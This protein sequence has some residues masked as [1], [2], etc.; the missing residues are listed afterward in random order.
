MRRL[1][2]PG[3]LEP[4]SE[5]RLPLPREQTPDDPAQTSRDALITPTYDY[6]VLT[7]AITRPDLHTHIFPG[8]LRLVGSA[9]V[10]WLINVDAVRTGHSVEA[11]IAN[12]ARLITAPNI[13]LEFLP[14]DGPGCFFQAA[15]RLAMRAGELLAQCRTGVVWLEDDWRLATRNHGQQAMSW[16]RY[17]V[18][19]NPDGAPLRRCL[20][21]LGAKQATLDAET[22]QRNALWFVSLVPRNLVSFN[23]GIW[24][25]ALFTRALLQT[26]SSRGADAVDDP[27]TLCADPMNRGATYRQLSLFIDPAYQDAGRQWSA[28][29]GLAKW[30]KAPDELSRRGS[31]T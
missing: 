21:D 2:Q 13:D 25:K 20:G 3:S 19:R 1:W 22:M 23:P 7:A 5:E 14:A 28:E 29:R 15:R 16:L 30:D 8:H 27:E 10:K 18:A 26:L 12:L 11:T 24:S 17:H 4:L 9:R 6:I 31:V